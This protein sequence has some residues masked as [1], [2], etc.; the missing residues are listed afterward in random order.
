VGKAGRR[1]LACAVAASI[2]LFA[3]PVT[4]SSAQVL[5][6]ATIHD[7]QK[8]VVSR[9]DQGPIEA[10]RRAITQYQAL[11]S[12]DNQAIAND[13]SLE[14]EAAAAH[15]GASSRLVSDTGALSDAQSALQAAA[16][17]VADDRDR[18]RALAVGT[19]TGQFT[20]PQPSGSPTPNADQQAA[21]DVAEVSVVAGIVDRRLRGDLDSVLAA[22]RLRDRLTSAVAGDQQQLS[23]TAAA[24]GA[25]AASLNAA[26]STLTSDQGAL[27]ASNAQLKRSEAALTADL[28]SLSGPSN[29][30]AGTVSLLGGSAL[31]AGQ[32]AAWY[33][34]EG[35][36]DLTSAPIEQLA[37]WYI[38]AGIQEG[39]RGD[40]AFAQAILETGGFSSPD[41]VDLNNYAGI[42]HCDSCSS[43][44]QFPSPY[45]GVVGQI[46]LL[47]I[48]ATTSAPPPGAPGPVLPSLTVSQQHE[49]GCCP[50]V[51]SLTGVWATDPTYGSQILS[52]YQQMLG[53]ALAQR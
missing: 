14:K 40:V 16:G 18:L 3:V 1:V 48:F 34:W 29:T 26:N 27:S 43:G 50:T 49:A 41:A 15:Q 44:W 13:I 21:I 9:N 32:L 23:V 2:A 39:L 52:I 20:N 45:G 37:S 38:Q 22:T 24:Q 53:F 30:P 46:Q 8:S 10:A 11:I 4:P 42:G 33:R 19:Y 5:D 36:G 47:R 51:E 7:E 12:Q 17:R 35:Y 28:A 31:N 25:A 6:A